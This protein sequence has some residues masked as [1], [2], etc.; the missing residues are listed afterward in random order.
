MFVLKNK[1]GGEKKWPCVCDSFTLIYL[2]LTGYS[3]GV[4]VSADVISHISKG[5]E[6]VRLV[7]EVQGRNETQLNHEF[8]I[9][10]STFSFSDREPR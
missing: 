10:N 9:P 6:G 2:S 5:F 1:T 7:S 8:F 4:L 3:L